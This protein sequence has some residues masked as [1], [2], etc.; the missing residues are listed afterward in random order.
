MYTY[1]NI[2]HEI[3]APVRSRDVSARYELQK[4][5]PKPLKS[6]RRAQNCTSAPGLRGGNAERP[7]EPWHFKGALR[8]G[9][10][11]PPLT[12]CH[13]TVLEPFYLAAGSID[14]ATPAGRSHGRSPSGKEFGLRPL[15]RAVRRRRQGALRSALALSLVGLAERRLR[16]PDPARK[17]LPSVPSQ[18]TSAAQRGPAPRPFEPAQSPSVC[19]SPT[20]PIAVPRRRFGAAERG[21]GART[22]GLPGPER[23]EPAWR[24]GRPQAR[25]GQGTAFSSR[26]SRMSRR[27]ATCRA[28][29]NRVLKRTAS[30]P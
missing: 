23:P 25:P 8:D 17:P 19:P 4:S 24:H 7:A 29:S 11:K 28:A 18:Q 14:F 13:P 22:V 26:S 2:L 12:R 6:L 15:H 9:A 21:H 10:Q 5:E 3:K 16:R 1:V 20:R 30:P 27:S